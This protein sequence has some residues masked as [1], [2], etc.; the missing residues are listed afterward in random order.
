MIYSLAVEGCRTIEIAQMLNEKSI[1]SPLTYKIRNGYINKPNQAIDPDCCFWT[2]SIVRK[3]IMN[4]VYVGKTISNKSKV[5]E[6]GTG[7]T[8]PQPESEWIVVPN[9]HEPLVSECDFQKAQLILQKKKY[10][11]K[12]KSKSNHIFKGKVKYSA[13]G[14]TM[15][16]HVC[17]NPYY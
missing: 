11:Q 5:T 10:D 7:H 14:H 2:N 4:E 15:T 9:T 1:P 16:R 12:H 17:K 3:L 13:C 8:A 6:P